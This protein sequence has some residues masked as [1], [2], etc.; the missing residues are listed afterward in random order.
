MNEKKLSL[1][2]SHAE[3]AISI[4]V[5]QQDQCYDKITEVLGHRPDS[6]N[7]I[8]GL[9]ELIEH[10]ESLRKIGTVFMV[11]EVDDQGPCFSRKE[12]AELLA[13][14]MH[15]KTDATFYITEIAV[16]LPRKD[17]E[18]ALY[19]IWHTKETEIID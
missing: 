11:A 1:E 18:A 2:L 5:G 13:A 9:F 8:S 14:K 6:I 16:D 19:R 3:A 17:S 10:Y 7:P 12:D 4:F 15:K